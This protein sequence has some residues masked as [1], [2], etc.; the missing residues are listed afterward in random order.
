MI[1]DAMSNMQMFSQVSKTSAIIKHTIYYGTISD[2]GTLTLFW[3]LSI[4]VD[5]DL[6]S[7]AFSS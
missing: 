5:L 7:D 2:F 4:E 6:H 1:I 3:D